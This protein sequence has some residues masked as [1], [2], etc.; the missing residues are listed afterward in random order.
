MEGKEF[1]W[2]YFDVHQPDGYDLVFSLHLKPFMSQFDVAIFDV[3]VYYRNRLR[4]HKF[5]IFDFDSLEIERQG[6][7]LKRIANSFFELECN[8]QNCKLSVRDEALK[9]DLVM[10]SQTSMSD[11]KELSFPV[12]GEALRTFRWLL[13]MPRAKASGRLRFREKKGDWQEIPINGRGYCDG[14]LGRFNLKEEL[15]FWLWMKI[16]QN[17][18]M[19]IAGKIFP[20]FEKAKHVVV[21]VRPDEIVH[22]FD[23]R[24]AL[25]K[26]E[27]RLE[28]P[29]GMQKFELQKS[30]LLDDLRF[31]IPQWP[32]VLQPLE[33]VRELLAALTLD[34]QTLRPL[35]NALTNGKYE[36]RRYLARYDHGNTVEIFGEEMFLNG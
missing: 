10:E 28:T 1:E 5:L 22:T 15:N 11:V 9:I 8:A 18:T 2:L 7:A 29:W 36:R 3:F 23:A 31:L 24:V 14:N 25:G 4:F 12:K 16:Y 19:W 32:K 34:R 17:D 20:R 13:Y 35:R 33:K 30:F 26:H 21:R 6:R 27:L